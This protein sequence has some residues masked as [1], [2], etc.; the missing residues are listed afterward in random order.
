VKPFMESMESGL[1][2]PLEEC[3]A[4]LLPCPPN[5]GYLS[6]RGDPLTHSPVDHPGL[7]VWGI[8]GEEGDGSRLPSS[9]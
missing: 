3:P 2:E 8:H 1:P 6:W 4:P 9:P 7:G 5:R